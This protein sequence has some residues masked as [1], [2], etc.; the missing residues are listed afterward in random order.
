VSAVG[1]TD[2]NRQYGSASP[3]LQGTCGPLGEALEAAWIQDWRRRLPHIR[4]CQPA[5]CAAVGG[6]RFGGEAVDR[7]ATPV[8]CINQS[9]IAGRGFAPAP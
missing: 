6:G 8:M 2:V 5:R 3:L 7:V 4:P 1:A 9:Y